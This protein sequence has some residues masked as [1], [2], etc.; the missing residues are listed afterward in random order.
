MLPVSLFELLD[1]AISYYNCCTEH[2]PLPNFY[3]V[4]KDDASRSFF[5]S[6]SNSACN[7]E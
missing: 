6:P 2:V 7:S 3:Q 4:V 1:S 5:V